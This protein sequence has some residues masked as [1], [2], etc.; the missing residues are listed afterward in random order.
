MTEYQAFIDFVK[1]FGLPLTLMF[2]FVLG[3]HHEWWVMGRTYK[4]AMTRET[5]SRTRAE[6]GEIEWRGMHR[7]LETEL[8]S[9]MQTYARVSVRPIPPLGDK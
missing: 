4:D 6:K 9:L 1:L 2:V 8:R 3:L 5:E 7:E